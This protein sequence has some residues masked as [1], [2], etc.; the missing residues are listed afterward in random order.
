MSSG[1]DIS[2]ANRDK[3]WRENLR[4][5][6]GEKAED[7]LIKIA[8]NS[9]HSE[10]TFMILATSFDFL[11]NTK[12]IFAYEKSGYINLS[13]LDGLRAIALLHV[14]FANDYWSRYVISQNLGDE[15]NLNLFKQSWIYC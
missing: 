12:R 7:E 9:G 15:Y 1:F 13:Y 8:K 3:S 14:M 10:S 6:L 5:G 2:V 4:Y 11:K